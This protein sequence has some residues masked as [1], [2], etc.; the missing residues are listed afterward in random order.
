MWF[1]S[2]TYNF[3]SSGVISE[4]ISLDGENWYANMRNPVY[5]GEWD[6]FDHNTMCGKVIRDQSGYKMY[7]I[8]E[9]RDK[10]SHG[11]GLA[12]SEDGKS[13]QRYSNTP[14]LSLG[15]QGAWNSRGYYGVDVIF[16]G[17]IYHMWYQ[18]IDDLSNG[19]IGYAT[20]EDGLHW[21]PYA[22]NPVLQPTPGWWDSTSVGS[23][24][25][26]YADNVFWMI[27]SGAM[28]GGVYCSFGLATSMDGIFWSRETLDPI[29]SPG[30]AEWDGLSLLKP[31]IICKDN[32]FQLWYS[33]LPSGSGNWQ[34]GYATSV[35]GQVRV[36]SNEDVPK[37]FALMQCYPNPFNPGTTIKYQV[38]QKSRVSLKVYDMLGRIIATL[39]EEEQDPGEKSISWNALNIAS[40][41]YFYQL[42]VGSAV[43]TKKMLLIR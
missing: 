32:L 3:G 16:D 9:S 14:L 24:A 18:G 19:S 8:G 7:Y 34:T 20:S 26:V 15:S 25:V 23:M 35:M 29:L 13:W 17:K 10:Q 33:G 6:T 38:P 28:K 30:P 2:I 27:Y 43:E 11:I 22:Q 42:R 4:A 5:A 40:G 39:V 37:T 31:A 21:T 41:P 12:T 1:T 36:E